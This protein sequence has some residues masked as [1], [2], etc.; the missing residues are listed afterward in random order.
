MKNKFCIGLFLIISCLSFGQ[1]Y[2]IGVVVDPQV[3][4]IS[5]E[6][7]RVDK[8]G[9]VIGIDGGLSID[10]YFQKNYAIHTGL[11]IGSQGGKL[12][13]ADP[14]TYKIDDA[15]INLPAGTVVTY[16]LNY[17][18][19][20]LALK[21]KTNQIGYFSYFAQLGFTNQFNIKAKAS[22]DDNQIEKDLIKKEIKLY[23]LSYHFGAGVEYELSEATALTVG[24]FYHN[25]FLDLTKKPGFVYSRA[26]TFSLGII[27]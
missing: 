26:L 24:I 22:S 4:W 11:T 10:K 20:P 2:K 8:E 18:T 5:S 1:G 14:L 21:L 9:N 7:K 3:T 23:N 17:L 13:Y 15:D 6:S 19:V 25:G 12:R 27:F 16:K